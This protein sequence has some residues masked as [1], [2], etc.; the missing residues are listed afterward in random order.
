MRAL[1]AL[2]PHLV[3]INLNDQGDGLGPLIAARVARKRTVATLHLVIPGRKGWRE[4]ISA[5]ALRSPE[6]VIAV[7][8]FVEDYA[9]GA[10]AN[11]LTVMNG[12][13][14]PEYEAEPRALLGLAPGETV[15][16]GIGRLHDQ[17]G[18][19]VF[20]AAAAL[21]REDYPETVFVVVGDGPDRVQLERMGAASGVRFL[22]Y[23]ES[24][25]AL[26][27]AF[28][29]VVA[30]SRYE[31][32][33]LVAIESMLAG[34]PIVATSV[35]GLPEVVADCG[36]LVAPERPDLLASAII[37]LLD[38]PAMRTAYTKRATA[39]ARSIFSPKR[40][41]ADTNRVYLAQRH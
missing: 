19:D 38:D 17:K 2:D 14:S 10:G 34:V 6:T 26:I 39:R 28:D 13:D 27:R 31:A 41:A 37:E 1:R 3:H 36:R 11:S 22:G 35:G 32:F 29:V 15:V 9:R 30:P 33:G 5:R 16:G 21:V 18:W 23:R 40:M 25:S 12:L 8:R 24:A 4:R 20:C 7:S